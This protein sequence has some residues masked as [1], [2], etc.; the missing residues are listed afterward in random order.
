MRSCG[1]AYN[2]HSVPT[3]LQIDHK[4]Y[5]KDRH[6]KPESFRQVLNQINSGIDPTIQFNLLYYSCHMVVTNIRKNPQ[7][8]K[9]VLEYLKKANILKEE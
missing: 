9:F 5:L 3:N 1:E 4:F 8:A 6:R 7:K 2:P